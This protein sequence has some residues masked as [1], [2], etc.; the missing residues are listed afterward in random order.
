MTTPPTLGEVVRD[1][2]LR[3]LSRV[4]R[5]QVIAQLV[6]GELTVTFE[7]PGDPRR[8]LFRRGRRLGAL[9]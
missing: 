9:D 3:E 1:L 8:V 5:D 2:Q 6:S 4:L 7:G